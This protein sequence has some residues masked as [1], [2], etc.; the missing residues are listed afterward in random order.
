MLCTWSLY[1][2]YSLCYAPMTT[3]L[4]FLLF[5]LH[6]QAPEGED[7]KLAAELEADAKE[8]E[9][10]AKGKKRKREAA[11]TADADEKAE[12]RKFSVDVLSFKV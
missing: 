10:A 9:K 6:D 4:C 11:A 2:V 5:P 7:A 3:S 1:D 8:L 12:K